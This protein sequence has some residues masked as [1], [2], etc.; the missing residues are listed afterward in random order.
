V[1]KKKRSTAERLALQEERK[2]RVTYIKL[3]SS[4]VK[5]EL[6]AIARAENLTSLSAL[7]HIWILRG[8]EQYKADKQMNPE[9][10]LIKF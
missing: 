2:N 3:P 8:L 10:K 5:Q 7:L 1:I 9:T 4:A 6:K